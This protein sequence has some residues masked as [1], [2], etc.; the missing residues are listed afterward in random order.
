MPPA[1]SISAAL[2]LLAKSI[3]LIES[4]AKTSFSYSPIVNATTVSNVNLN[5]SQIIL[6]QSIIPSQPPSPSRPSRLFGKLDYYC[7]ANKIYCKT[8]RAEN[9]EP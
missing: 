5:I 4:P 8:D 2:L 1:P 6:I 7:L 3:I 9:R